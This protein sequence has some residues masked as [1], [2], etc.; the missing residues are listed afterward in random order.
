MRSS[1][2]LQRLMFL[3]KKL[4]F[5]TT[6]MT[7]EEKEYLK[8]KSRVILKTS[9]PKARLEILGTTETMSFRQ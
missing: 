1:E 4:I 8:D 6:P 3:M 2:I 9:T 5:I 7:T